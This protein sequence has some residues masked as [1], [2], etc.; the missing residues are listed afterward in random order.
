MNF[1]KVRYNL[2]VIG[3]VALV[4]CYMGMSIFFAPSTSNINNTGSAQEEPVDD[5]LFP[6]DDYDNEDYDDEDYDDES[7]IPTDGMEL[8]NYGL[9]ILNNGS[10]YECILTSSIINAPN[11]PMDI[12]PVQNLTGVIARGV[13]SK[14]EKV[15]YEKNFYYSNYS[16]TGGGSLARYFRG[17]YDKQTTGQVD[18][19]ETAD[20]NPTALTYNK[21]AARLSETVSSDAAL[22]KYKILYTKDFP[23]TFNAKTCTITDDNP[24]ADKNKRT[25]TV[26]YKV[27][28]LPQVYGEYYMTT[29]EM[30]DVKYQS[31]KI[32]FVI[33]KKNGYIMSIERNEMFTAT[34]VGI[35]VLGTIGITSSIQTKQ[36]FSNMN[37]DVVIPDNL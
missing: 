1:K 28:A 35:E 10:G 22:E 37:K 30:R 4:C 23:L 19:L 8:I 5:T 11:V 29:G 33:N 36:T 2:I 13:N 27:A 9:N 3:L 7:D 34:A 12:S 31:V 18:V 24:K 26:V 14:G 25:I 17:F 21:N 15:G 16:G 20:Y 6:D 32:T